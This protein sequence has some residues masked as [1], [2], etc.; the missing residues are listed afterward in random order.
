MSCCCA[1]R[2]L[3][4][5][6]WRKIVS[7]GLPGVTANASIAVPRASTPM[8][9]GTNMKST[10]ITMK[11][12]TGLFAR[13]VAKRTLI[14]GNITRSATARVRIAA[15]K[16]CPPMRK[17]TIISPYTTMSLHIGIPARSA[18]QRARTSMSIRCLVWR[19]IPVYAKAAATRRRIC[20]SITLT[21]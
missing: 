10:S 11:P 9:F 15:Q 13:S 20:G 3:R 16:V 4:C 19:L 12:A 1:W 17:T 5:R 6:H 2:F 21:K 7:T 18:A 14:F 8:T